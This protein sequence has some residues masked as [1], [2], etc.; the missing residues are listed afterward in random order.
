MEGSRNFGRALIVNRVHSGTTL[1]LLVIL[2][3][4]LLSLEHRASLLWRA[5]R[6]GCVVAFAVPYLSPDDTRMR[7][8]S[9]T[10]IASIVRCF[11]TKALYGLVQKGENLPYVHTCLRGGVMPTGDDT[12]W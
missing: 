7:V 4:H 12:R 6:A 10:F 9:L 1:P 5:D 3:A 8:K 11:P 2:D